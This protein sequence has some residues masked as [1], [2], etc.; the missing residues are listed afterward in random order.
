MADPAGNNFA[1]YQRQTA[2]GPL[3]VA[4]QRRLAAGRVLIVGVGG[5]GS[6]AAELLARAGVGFLRLA[7]ADRV[8]RTNIHR[9]SLYDEDDA[10]V[11]R[12]KVEAAAARLARINAD[13][14]VEPV[15][16]RLDADNVAAL[17]DGVDLI[18]DGTDNFPS[19]FVLND[20][21][22][23]AGRPWVFAGVVGAEGQVLPVLPGRTACLR[24]L[25]DAPPPPCQD[26]SCQ[27]AGV[28]GPAVAAI[29]A[30]QA[31]EAVKILSGRIEAVRG[32]LLKLDLWRNT[33]QRI[34]TGSPRADCE[35]C[36]R[37]RFEYLHP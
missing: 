29:S 17:A 5:L 18:L 19:R 9:Q 14:T 20:Y 13:V 30:V 12:P 7:D 8:D 34:D 4:G 37:R 31:A 2:F 10:R 16:A 15:A 33:V 35:C 6:W 27:A 36:V 32:H 23:Q 26:P 28:L 24:C 3:A 1:R 21:A 11:R 22:V 25:Y